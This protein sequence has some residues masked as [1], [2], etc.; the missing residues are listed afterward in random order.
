MHAIS[1]SLGQM[2]SENVPFQAVR[3][4]SVNIFMTVTTLITSAFVPA[5]LEAQSQ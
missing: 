2:E 5:V 3:H 4:G 1:L